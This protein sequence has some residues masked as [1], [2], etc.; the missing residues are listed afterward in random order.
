MRRVGGSSYGTGGSI[1]MTRS[2]STCRASRPPEPSG[3]GPQYWTVEHKDGLIYTYGGSTDSRVLATDSYAV[4]SV[5]EWKLSEIRDLAGNKVRF[6]WSTPD[7]VSSWTTTHLTK[8]EWTQTSHGSGSYLNSMEFNYTAGGNAPA[9][10]P[11]SYL[12]GNLMQDSDL[13][14]DITVKVSGTVVR[15]YVL[16]YE[17]SSITTAKRLIHVTECSNGAATRLPVAHHHHLSG[18]HLRHQH[19]QPVAEHQRQHHRCQW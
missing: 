8:V 7:G 12:L 5:A 13:L 17:D 6:T 11:N 14:A 18:W 4:T 2:C 19:I 1:Y 9:S 3:N 15:K 16:E 10:T